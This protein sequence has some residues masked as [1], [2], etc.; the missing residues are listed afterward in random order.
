M[1]SPKRSRSKKA[2]RD[3]ASHR[4]SRYKK[5]LDAG[6]G[7]WDKI[8]PAIEPDLLGVIERRPKHGPCLVHGGKDGL[9]CF[10]DFAR[11]GGMVC[12]TCGKFPNAILVVAC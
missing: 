9:R 10:D 3:D 8:L 7:H 11:A 6:D 2:F 12:N 5:C 4:N 1:I